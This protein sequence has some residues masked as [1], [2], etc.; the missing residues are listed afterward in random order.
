[1][2]R[3]L[4][5][6]Y[7][8]SPVSRSRTGLR[9]GGA[10]VCPH[11]K[12]YLDDS[13]ARLSRASRRAEGCRDAASKIVCRSATA[14]GKVADSNRGSQD[15]IYVARYC[16]CHGSRY[17]APAKRVRAA[18]GAGSGSAFGRRPH[19]GR[20]SFNYDAATGNAAPDSAGSRLYR[21]ARSLSEFRVS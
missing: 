8:P 13:S 5:A 21:H 18:S 2:G 16:R 11:F 1:M 3:L 6:R 9:A 15:A 14:V 19:S 4:A 17:H 7:M 20:T 12:G 10:E